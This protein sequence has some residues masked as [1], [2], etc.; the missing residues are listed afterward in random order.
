MRELF[1][2]FSW[3]DLRQHPWRSLAAAVAV[4]LGV[5]LGLAVHLINASALTEFAQATQAISGQSDVQLRAR[6][7]LL[8]QRFFAAVA[9]Q[10]LVAQANPVLEATVQAFTEAGH[11][12]TLH[13]TGADAL[14]LPATAP[15]LMPRPW[16][17]SARLVMLAPDALFL[18]ASARK[19]L[20]L[21]DGPAVVQ[22]QIGLKRTAV[23]VAGSVPATGQPVGVMD[24]GAAQD[25]L[26]L[27][28]WLT[29]IDVRLRPGADKTAL[30]QALDAHPDT[31]ARLLSTTPHNSIT[32]ADQLSRAYRVN[33]TAL[34]LVALFTGAYLVYSVLALALARRLPQFALLGVL[35]ATP[36]QRLMLMLGE[37]GTLGLIGAVA[38][39]LLG[40]LLA[41]AA[42][43]LAGGD[44][45]GGYFSATSRLHWS[46]GAALGYM[47][48]GLAAALVGG[49]WP[50]RQARELAP[51]QALKGLGMALMHGNARLALS[52]VVLLAASAL[53]ALL[54]PV[55]GIPI[56]AYL[57]VA[58]LL[59]GGIALLPW[60]VE[61]LLGAARPLVAQRALPMLA[62]ER[63]LRTRGAAAATIGGVVAALS[64][65]VALTVMVASFRSSVQ[66]WL[67]AMLPAPLYV[68]AS[69]QLKGDDGAVF[70]QELVND[71]RRLPGLAKLQASRSSSVQLSATQPALAILARP[72]GDHPERSL[73]MVGEPLPVPAGH[74]GLYVSEAVLDLHGVRPGDGWPALSKAFHSGNLSNQ[75]QTAPFFIAGVWRDY[76]RQTGAVAMRR[77]DFI[78]LTGDTRASDLALWPAPGTDLGALRETIM[79]LARAQGAAPG[80]LEFT[81]TDVIRQR[82]LAL[83]DRS[84]AVTYWLQAVAIAIGMFGVAASLS[85][86]VLA[87]RKEFGLL[88]HL[89]LTRRQILTVVAGE[90]VA[91][92]AVG[93]VVGT[94]LGLAVALVLVRVVNPQS[95]HWSMDLAIP[96]P[97]L[98]LLAG[99]VVLAGGIT[100]LLAG[101]SAASHDAVLAVKEDW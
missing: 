77:S 53:L 36:S 91:W 98:G 64:L 2:T 46:G 66:H 59:I 86:Q 70:T 76:V 62:M 67:D 80:A 82:S 16:P 29:R 11:E 9:A 20:H 58:L 69:G 22:L 19:A 13:L 54:P 41:W 61:A 94:L 51:A 21:A 35:G 26:G 78:G 97:R 52:G 65:A 39:V 92:T 5:A 1:F 81:R 87:R 68:R 99:A 79:T 40:T 45:G 75:A 84:F 89:G 63:A 17:G 42:L 49:W 23:Q 56:A 24:I 83:F 74:I 71:I 55:L 96:W 44:L 93:A 28:G 8:P 25:L 100:A 27:D 31:A 7:G 72:L 18:N 95:F 12:V 88:T 4:M 30:E 43:R 14:Q 47:L 85:A 10:P 34:A 37:A 3:Q 38:G 6:Q 90:G 48:L 60:P 73:P 33:L 32:Q 101:R 15:A 57:S 50:A